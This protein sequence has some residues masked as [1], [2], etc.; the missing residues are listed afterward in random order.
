MDVYRSP[1]SDRI[2]AEM[3]QGTDG[4]V[5]FAMQE[6]VNF[7]WTKEELPDERKLS[8]TVSFHKNGDKTFHGI[9]LI[10]NS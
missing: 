6:L 8:I 5:V 2:T 10:S 3:I 9:S 1:G 7:L 4:K